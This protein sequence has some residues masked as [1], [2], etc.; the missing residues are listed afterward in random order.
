MKNMGKT[1]AGVL[2]EIQ[3]P[4]YF[5]MADR[6]ALRKGASSITHCWLL[7]T[8]LKAL[9]IKSAT[10]LAES[11]IALYTGLNLDL[12]NQFLN[13]GQSNLLLLRLPSNCNRASNVA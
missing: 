5:V 10:L 2:H 12:L 4:V 8:I 1:E 13:L 3:Y 11:L 7:L 9:A 6:K